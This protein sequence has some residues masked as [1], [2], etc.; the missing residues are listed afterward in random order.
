MDNLHVSTMFHHWE[1]CPEVS[2]SALF[3][4]LQLI[5]P[6]LWYLMCVFAEVSQDK[7][8]EVARSH[9]GALVYIWW[10]A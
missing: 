10:E 1:Q 3:L 5:L 2:E 8:A 6:Y 7:D 9:N 4:F